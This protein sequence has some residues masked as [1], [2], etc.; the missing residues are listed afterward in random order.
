[1]PQIPVDDMSSELLFSLRKL[2]LRLSKCHLMLMNNN[3]LLPEFNVKLTFWSLTNKSVSYIREDWSSRIFLF[4]PC[5]FSNFNNYW[6]SKQHK[7]I[8]VLLYLYFWHDFVLVIKKIVI[9][10]FIFCRIES[11]LCAEILKP[12]AKG[13]ST[14]K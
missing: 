5:G 9:Y 14:I 4:L 1:M 13:S 11:N 7:Y 2:C 3:I 10:F 12:W 6:S 8:A